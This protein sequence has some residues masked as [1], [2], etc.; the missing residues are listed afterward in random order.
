MSFPS[1][2]KL[3]AA[4]WPA[5]ATDTDKADIKAWGLTI[6]TNLNALHSSFGMING[7]L[8]ASV[9]ANALTIAVKTH[10]GEDPT[11][12][13]PVYIAFRSSTA[14]N[15]EESVVALTAALSLTVSGGSTLGGISGD[16]M[17]V[18]VVVFNDAGTLR[19]GVVNCFEVGIVHPL[20]E[21][22]LKSSTAEGGAGAADS[23]G[24]IYTGSAV[25]SKP[26][27]ILGYMTW[28]AN[29]LATAGLYAS[30]PDVV[31][32]MGPGVRKPGDVVQRRRASDAAVNTTTTTTPVDDTIPQL[33]T[34]G[35]TQLTRTI[36]PT[37]RANVILI[38]SS[39]Q[40]AIS[41]AGDV[42]S[43]LH[44]DSIENALMAKHAALGAADDSIIISMR[45]QYRPLTVS[46]VTYKINNGP[47][48][49]TLTMNGVGGTRTFGGINYSTLDV[50]EIFV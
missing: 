35:E 2:T 31:Q 13:D 14:T 41:A 19:L 29:A 34:E 9:N 7:Q 17:R 40:L 21:D 3:A 8:A 49:G 12:G 22:Q 18:W 27:R 16:A 5:T 39:V 42:T 4:V 46:E 24:V 36:T 47:S 43:A 33:S 37:S 23:A 1:F 44:Q 10:A 11:S 48:T 6:E 26:F 38:E 15:G 25:T 28:E 30:A 20:E 45:H 50:T 32:L